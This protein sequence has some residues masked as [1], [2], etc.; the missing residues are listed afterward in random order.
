MTYH[1]FKIARIEHILSAQFIAIMPPRGR[2]G[3]SQASQSQTQRT[4]ASGRIST[5]P[6]IFD[7]SATILDDEEPESG[8]KRKRRRA[9]KTRKVDGNLVTFISDEGD[10]SDDDQDPESHLSDDVFMRRAYTINGINYMRRD[11]I[12]MRRQRKKQLTSMIWQNDKNGKL[13]GFAIAHPTTPQLLYYCCYCNGEN[14]EKTRAPFTLDITKGHT[15]ALSHWRNKHGIDEKGNEVPKG[16]ILQQVADH[17]ANSKLVNGV[18]KLIWRDNFELF[19]LL[20]IR[21]IVYC[22][23]AISMVDNLY[24][25]SFLKHLNTP[26]VAYLAGRNTVRGWVIA[27]YA[28]RKKWLQRDLKRARQVNLLFII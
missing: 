21:W 28:K 26:Y 18:R 10:V 3:G 1:A 14:G 22:H 8:Q 12:A 4:T 25:L 19:K 17:A 13:R 24:F 2:R 11:D 16:N 5:Q 7:N 15:H 20:L 27:E 9:Q 6:S 23:I